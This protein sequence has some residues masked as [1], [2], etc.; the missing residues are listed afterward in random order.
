MYENG[1]RVNGYHRKKI[2][3]RILKKKHRIWYADYHTDNTNADKEYWKQFYLTG[4]RKV[5]KD[6]TNRKIRRTYNKYNMLNTEDMARPTNAMYRKY[7]D[8]WWTIF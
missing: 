6:C 1:K 3:K 8:Y 4:P 2:H 5:A 7:F